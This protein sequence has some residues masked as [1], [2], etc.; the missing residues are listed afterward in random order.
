MILVYD[1]IGIGWSR[2]ILIDD[3]VAPYG[4]VS[5]VIFVYR[6]GGGGVGIG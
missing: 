6:E 5:T 3:T 2:V 1:S 4:V